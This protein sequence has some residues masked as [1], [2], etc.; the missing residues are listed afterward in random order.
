MQLSSRIQFFLVLLKRKPWLGKENPPTI[1]FCSILKDTTTKQEPTILKPIKIVPCHV[2]Y[3][4][5][6]DSI[7]FA[8]K[9]SISTAQF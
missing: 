4:E 1:P 5:A 3:Y 2:L 8:N 6:L 7:I 9:G